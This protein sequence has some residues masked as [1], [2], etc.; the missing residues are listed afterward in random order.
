MA[1]RAPIQNSD[2]KKETLVLLFRNE[3]DLVLLSLD[4]YL[5]CL[6]DVHVFPMICDHLWKRRLLRIFAF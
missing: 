3:N 4:Q 5:I 6:D 2:D 1:Q